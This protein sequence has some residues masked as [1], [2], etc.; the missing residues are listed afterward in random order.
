[1]ILRRSPEDFVRPEPS[2]PEILGF[3]SGRLRMTRRP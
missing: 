1:V 3:P 2:P